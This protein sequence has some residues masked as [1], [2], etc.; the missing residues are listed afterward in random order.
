MLPPAMR[1][2]QRDWLSSNLFVFFDGEGDAREATVVDTGYHRHSAQTVALV[3]HLLAREGLGMD[4]LRRIVNTHLHSDHCG[5]NLALNRASGAR[6]IVPASQVDIVRRWDTEALTFQDFCQ[7]CERFPAHEGLAPGDDIRM[8]GLLWRAHAAPGHDPDSLVLHCPEARLLISAD[9][10]WENGFGVIFPELTGESGFAEQATV[11][12]TIEALPV[13][14]ALPGHGAAITDVPAAIA[15]ARSRLQAFLDDPRRSPR[16]GV[17][18]L[19][20][21]M[22]LG[23]ERLPLA[24]AQAELSASRTIGGAAAQLGLPAAEAVRRSIDELLDQG[25]LGLEPDGTLINLEPAG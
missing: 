2:V 16:N 22:M 8:G 24:Q 9:A 1:F 10:L 3:A 25:Q 4:R 21:F 15:R 7:H 14:V 13:D 18:V 6:V 11:L 5:G 20:K 19:I 12:D 23:R 17:K